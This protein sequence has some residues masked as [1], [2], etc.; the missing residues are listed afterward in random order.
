MNKRTIYF[1]C[2]IIF[3][4]I[5]FFT[6]PSNE[7]LIPLSAGMLAIL[8]HNKLMTMDIIDEYIKTQSKKRRIIKW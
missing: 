1:G 2:Y 8:T 3:G 6:L 5:A 4:A 7:Y